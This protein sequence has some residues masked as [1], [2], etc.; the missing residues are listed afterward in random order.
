MPFLDRRWLA[1][2][3]LLLLVAF[4]AGVYYGKHLNTVAA[5]QADSYEIQLLATGRTQNDAPAGYI[6]VFVT[7]AVEESRICRL[8]PGARVYQAVDMARA[9]PEANLAEVDMARV[10]E[11]G[12]TILVHSLDPEIEEAIFGSLPES[13]VNRA[14][15]ININKASPEEISSALPGIGPALSERIVQYREANGRFERP[16]DICNVTGI[17][18]KKY[19]A[20]CDLITVR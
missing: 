5:Q 18:N 7:G 11:D 14:G 2:L 15:K 16:E 17:G 13:A 12:E 4:L 19:E 8:L 6:E 9:L 10:L 20:I 3:A 1:G